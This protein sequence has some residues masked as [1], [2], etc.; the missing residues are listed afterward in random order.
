[1]HASLADMLTDVVQNSVEA[2]AE[3]ISIEYEESDREIRFS[4]KDNGRGM[5]RETLERALDPFWSDGEKHP[6]RRVGLGIPFLRQTAQQCGGTVDIESEPQKGTVVRGVFPA[7]NLDLPPRGNLV[8]LWLQCLTFEGTYGMTI[9]RVFRDSSGKED[10]YEIDRDEMSR[11]LDGLESVG[12]RGLLKEYIE[13]Q[14]DSVTG[15]EK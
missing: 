13:S 1:M 2:A 6:G 5:S 10:G 9:R 4:V 12:S 7:D 8:L 15:N 14:E 3:H 11:V